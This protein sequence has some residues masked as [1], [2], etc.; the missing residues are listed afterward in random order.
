MLKSHEGT[1]AFHLS[2]NS[3]IWFVLLSTKALAVPLTKEGNRERGAIY[4]RRR[5]QRVHLLS[6]S[7]T[8]GTQQNYRST[9][10]QIFNR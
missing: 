5:E 7:F 6:M 9:S 4:L 2:T 1:W 8:P 10:R 3:D